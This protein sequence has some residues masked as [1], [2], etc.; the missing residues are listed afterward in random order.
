MI[1]LLK[2]TEILNFNERLLVHLLQKVTAGYLAQPVFQ[3]MLRINCLPSYEV[4]P[5][6]KDK[7]ALLRRPHDDPFWPDMLHTPGTIVRSTDNMGTVKKRVLTGELG[8]SQDLEPTF[9]GNLFNTCVRGTN[10]AMV[11]WLDLD[12]SPKDAVL[13]SHEEL[14]DAIIPDQRQIANLAYNNYLQR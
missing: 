8:V 2:N 1:D 14:N 5:I 3:E 7:V 4:V 10:L 13:V 6:V 9:A 11:H 12:T